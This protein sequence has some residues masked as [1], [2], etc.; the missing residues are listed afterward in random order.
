[1]APQDA[2]PFLIQMG[3][4]L[5]GAG[6]LINSRLVLSRARERAAKIELPQQAINAYTQIA[7]AEAKMGHLAGAQDA[8]ALARKHIAALH[9]GSQ[10]NAY[11]TLGNEQAKV[12]EGA[13]AESFIMA[14]SAIGRLPPPERPG[15]LETLALIM[16]Q[17]GRLEWARALLNQN[18]EGKKLYGLSELAKQ[19]GLKYSA[20][21]NGEILSYASVTFQEAYAEVL[22][23]KEIYD[24]KDVGY[25]L[26]HLTK[27]AL[28]AGPWFQSK[29]LEWL[30]EYQS[31]VLEKVKDP[32]S[33]NY[34]LTQVGH[35]LA[36]A[37]AF[38]AALDWIR[39]Y[40]SN[41]DQRSGSLK[42]LALKMIGSGQMEEAVSLLKR[43][44]FYPSHVFEAWISLADAWKKSRPPEPRKYNQ[45]LIQAGKLIL[46]TEFYPHW[47]NR[48]LGLLWLAQRWV[49]QAG[50][51]RK[52]KQII[53]EIRSS[54]RAET[55]EPDKIHQT[56]AEIDL[57]R[58]EVAALPLLS[59]GVATL[60]AR[61]DSAAQA[62]NF[63]KTREISAALG[64]RSGGLEGDSPKLHQYPPS[65]R[66]W[67]KAW[68]Y[69]G[70]A[71]HPRPEESRKQIAKILRDMV[72]AHF[73]SEGPW[74]EKSHVVALQAMRL[75]SPNLLQMTLIEEIRNLL[76]FRVAPTLPRGVLWLN[77]LEFPDSNRILFQ[78]LSWLARFGSVVNKAFVSDLLSAPNFPQDWKGPI[79]RS[80]QRHG[81]QPIFQKRIWN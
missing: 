54:L 73:Y 46:K 36:K 42:I 58:L 34:Q 6:G 2:V 28:D 72:V 37:G 1:M 20:T 67:A 11:A 13:A 55:H 5:D 26:A 66:G 12:S 70:A 65:I 52:V 31:W 8:F 19:W 4:K 62:K 24:A 75:I 21:E 77:A 78:S 63:R 53:S 49:G 79:G 32:A 60:M 7:K 22:R 50:D 25:R 51:R 59:E 27:A 43:E 69:Y 47:V 68:F 57:L 29:G 35:L 41:P 30:G 61:L 38:K 9:P 15:A 16:A 48:P 45:A 3:I 23:C 44:R 56:L 40:S 81:F 33:R 76:E 64:F 39:T 80:L 71:L 18:P 10:P 17:S 14:E 74:L